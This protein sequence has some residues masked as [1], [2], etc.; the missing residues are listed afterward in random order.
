MKFTPVLV[1]CALFASTVYTSRPMR[2]QG[3]HAASAAD[4]E[5]VGELRSKSRR[6][7]PPPPPISSM[8]IAAQKTDRIARRGST[9][10]TRPAATSRAARILTGKPVSF[11][12]VSKGVDVDQRERKS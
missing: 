6:N 7:I 4:H 10:C 12:P 1:A 11:Y 5:V 9:R 2:R 8:R 3:R